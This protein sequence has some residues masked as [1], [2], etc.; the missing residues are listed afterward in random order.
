MGELGGLPQ[1][2]L[3]KSKVKIGNTFR[4][5]LKMKLDSSWKVHLFWASFTELEGTLQTVRGE[6]SPMVLTNYK[7]L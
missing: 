7:N 5:L 1:V 2:M 3:P 4:K 6:M